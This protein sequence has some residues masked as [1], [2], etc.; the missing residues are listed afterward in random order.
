MATR[1]EKEEALRLLNLDW[2][3]KD[4]PLKEGTTNAVPGE[5]NAD[6]EVLF[7]GEAPGKNEDLQGRP[8]VGAAGKFLN[9]LIGVAGF[10]REDVF[11]ANVVKHRPPGNRDPL[12][13]EIEAYSPWLAEQIE[14]IDP[15]LIVT[16]GRFSMEYMLG[17][18]FAISNVHGEA[19]R[20]KGRVIFPV[21]HPAAALY[22]GGLREVLVADFAKI[23]KVLKLVGEAKTPGQDRP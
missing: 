9:E 19:K 16:L 7:I 12:P 13:I 8:F 23:P 18:G 22:N 14:I 4:L 20:R 11:I 10:K 17:S 2:E 5:G 6:A 15:K 21:Y 1:E 3:T